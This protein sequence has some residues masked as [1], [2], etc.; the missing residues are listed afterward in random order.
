MGKGPIKSVTK[1]KVDVPEIKKM[2][3]FEQYKARG[4]TSLSDLET[5]MDSMGVYRLSIRGAKP[6]LYYDK[7][8]KSPF[9][10]WEASI[11]MVGA[12]S[13]WL[14]SGDVNS[15]NEALSIVFQVPVNVGQ[16]AAPSAPAPIPAAVINDGEL[17]V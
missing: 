15:L 1:F 3:G 10:K 16:T 5:F 2:P 14:R 13:E 8:P 11:T 9:G 7:Q 4:I 12:D 17:L 6:P